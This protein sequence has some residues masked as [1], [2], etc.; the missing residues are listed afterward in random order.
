MPTVMPA[1]NPCGRNTKTLQTGLYAPET[2][3]VPLVN[4]EK[5]IICRIQSGTLSNASLI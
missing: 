2:G 5:I 1:A 4:P 3:E